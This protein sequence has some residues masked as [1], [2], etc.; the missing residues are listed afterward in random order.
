MAKEWPRYMENVVKPG[1]E[2]GEVPRLGEEDLQSREAWWKDEEEKAVN[3]RCLGQLAYKPD[4]L[5]LGNEEENSRELEHR[6]DSKEKRTPTKREMVHQYHA[7]MHIDLLE[8]FR[9]QGWGRKMIQRF[10]EG[11]KASG[12][13]FGKG[14]MIGIA[15]ENEKVVKFYEKCGFRVVE[16]GVGEIW[17]VR[18]L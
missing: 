1:V 16:G 8:P 13:D 4:W 11:I 7:I 14:V 5:L 2:D 12:E 10:I 9:R 15:P 18:E 17:M 6:P 3:E